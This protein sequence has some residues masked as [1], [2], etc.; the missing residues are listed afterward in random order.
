[1][2]GGAWGRAHGWPCGGDG[3]LLAEKGARETTM[4]GDAHGGHFPKAVAGKTSGADFH[5]QGSRTV[6]RPA[7]RLACG[8]GL[9]QGS[10]G[11]GGQV[12]Q[13]Q[14]H[15]RGSPKIRWERWFP[16]RAPL[17]ETAGPLR[18]QKSRWVPLPSLNPQCG[19]RDTCRA[20]LTRTL[21]AQRPLLQGPCL[22]ALV[23]RIFWVRLDQ[24]RLS[25]RLS[26]RPA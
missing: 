7:G 23:Q 16:L 4:R 20:R 13:R 18:G 6:A 3:A 17:R 12:T 5:G 9:P 14:M 1:M 24:S 8:L 2:W 10:G 26:Q 25:E 21:A 19:C 15:N 11:G 22:C